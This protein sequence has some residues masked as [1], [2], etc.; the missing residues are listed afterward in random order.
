MAT[1]DVPGTESSSPAFTLFTVS[2]GR[3]E[4]VLS[5]GLWVLELSSASQ[6]LLVVGFQ[7]SFFWVRLLNLLRLFV[8]F[9]SVSKWT[10]KYASHIDPLFEILKIE[11]CFD[12]FLFIFST[13]KDHVVLLPEEYYTAK[14]LQP[15]GVQPCLAGQPKETICNDYKYISLKSF[16][17]VQGESGTNSKGFGFEVVEKTQ[18]FN[19]PD[20]LQQ[21]PVINDMA[22]LSSKQVGGFTDLFFL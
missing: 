2:G 21:L 14:K 19:D 10:R 22:E 20:I 3:R 12:F 15:D 11:K 16:Q 8:S 18:L 9:Q 17:S 6:T 4:I 7:V 5:K 13:L 1:V